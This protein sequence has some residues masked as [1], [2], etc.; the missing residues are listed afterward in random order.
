MVA[1]ALGVLWFTG[2]EEKR[3]RV[4]QYARIAFCNAVAL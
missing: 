1:I 2:S 3:K 4:P